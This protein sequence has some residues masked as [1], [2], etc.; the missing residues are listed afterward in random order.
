MDS[1]T[2]KVL[3]LS[4]TSFLI[5]VLKKKDT[6]TT[7]KESYSCLLT[8][9]LNFSPLISLYPLSLPNPSL[10]CRC[11][12]WRRIQDVR[13]FLLQSISKWEEMGSRHTKTKSLY[14]TR[15]QFN[16]TRGRSIMT[17]TIGP[18]LF[19]VWTSRNVSRM[20]LKCPVS[21]GRRWKE[22]NEP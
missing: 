4:S 1:L 8:S 12:L 21:E 19:F 11:T 2:T 18:F 22:K 10:S 3:S 6:I 16:K 17:H 13:Y 20:S 7:P 9:L 14:V 15:K 5:Y